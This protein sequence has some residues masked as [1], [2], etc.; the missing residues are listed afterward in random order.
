MERYTGFL[1][2][3]RTGPVVLVLLTVGAGIWGVRGIVWEDDIAK[4]SRLD[5]TLLA[6]ERDLQT[7]LSRWDQGRFMVAMGRD[8]EQALQRNETLRS[9]LRDQVVD[10]SLGA[11]ETLSD[12][13]WSE[14]LQ[15]RNRA[16]MLGDESLPGRLTAV[17]QENGFRPESFDD[18]VEQLDSMPP[19]LALSDLQA[20]GLGD[21]SQ[22]MVLELPAGSD[23]VA[24]LTFLSDVAAPAQLAASVRDLDGVF[25]FEQREF[26]S[27]IYGE[28]R[29]R[30][31]GVVLSGLGLVL[32][33]LFLRYRRLRP[34]LA[35]LLPSLLTA[36]V[37]V[38][39]A[40]LLSYELNLVHLLCLVLVMGIG[41]DYGIF[42]VDTALRGEAAGP[43][44]L[45]LLISCLTTLFVF[46]TLAISSYP[47]LRAMGL[48]TA[49]GLLASFLS[50]PAALVL[51]ARPRDA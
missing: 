13:L 31:V 32:L 51:L 41:V 8:L 24:I 3:H 36:F 23:S 25:L 12:L 28:Y 19:P 40:R 9:R 49:V 18:L 29:R 20:S 21:I 47:P 35:S 46:G 27:G 43:T 1:V 2:R 7:Q 30:V 26:I 44:Q 50:A 38:G 5:A 39:L 42:T 14:S 34:T 22:A 45:S 33:I 17:L 37:L 16:V 6:Q 10:G 15:R 48:T 11:F 4:L